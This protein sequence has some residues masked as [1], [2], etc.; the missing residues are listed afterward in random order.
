MF[1]RRIFLFWVI[2]TGLS[3]AS[4]FDA[5]AQDDK[6]SVY[7]RVMR[8]GVIRCGYLSWTNYIDIDVNTGEMSGIIYDYMTALA[9]NLGLKL[10]W[11]EEVG[12]ADYAQALENGR[13]DVYCTAMTRNAERARVSDFTTPIAHALFNIYTKYGDERFDYDLS[14]INN[15]DVSIV[16]TEGDIFGK[17]ARLEFPKAKLIELSQLTQDSDPYMYVHH[18]KADITIGNSNISVRYM[19]KNPNSLRKIKLEQPFRYVP[20]SL[21]VKADEY[22]FRRMLDLATEEMITNGKI[23]AMLEKYD[24][25]HD[26]WLRLAKPYEKIKQK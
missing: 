19:K 6:E 24:T 1:I 2:L 9:N 11:T 12:R 20:L 10:E 8:T 14:K 15:P 21:V 25:N 16:A 26:F 22:R 5:S 23:D 13:F 18:G 3:F 4:V 17:I 7:E